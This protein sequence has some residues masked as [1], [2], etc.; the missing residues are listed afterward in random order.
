MMIIMM[1]MLMMMIMM[2]KN[3]K[4]PTTI[5][6]MHTLRVYSFSL[7]WGSFCAFALRLH[8]ELLDVRADREVK[9][10]AIARLT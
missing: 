3:N 5:V 2:M 4:S 8:F 7:S 1:L 9:P 10:N 6:K